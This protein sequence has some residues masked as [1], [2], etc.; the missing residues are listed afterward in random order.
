MANDKI[1]NHYRFLEAMEPYRGQILTTS[2]IGEI[3]KTKFPEFNLGS[4]LPNDHSDA[5]NE[6]PCWCARTDERIFNRISTGQY[7]IFYKETLAE[8][9]KEIEASEINETTKKTLINARIGQGKFREELIEYWQSCAVTKTALI[10]VLKASHIKPWSSSSNEERLD[11]FNGL[12]L[13]P[14]LDTLFD[15]GYISFQDDGKIMIS[16]RIENY[17]SNFGVTPAMTISNL[18]EQHFKYLEVHRNEVY[19]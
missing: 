13:T 16:S 8:N 17:S 18:S 15:L 11:K 19:K 6:K 9:I 10:P 3:L 14:N 5:G 2:R 7:Q 1:T 4:N 12:L